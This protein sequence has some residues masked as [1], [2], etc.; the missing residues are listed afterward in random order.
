MKKLALLVLML[1]SVSAMAQ[2]VRV[3]G[4]ITSLDGDVLSVKSREGKDMKI[5]LAPD[6]Q[7][8]T[9]KKVKASEFKPGS[10]VGVTSVKNAEGHLVAKRVHA[11]GPQ[12]PQMHGAWDSIPGSM[13]TNSNITEI[14][15]MG[16]GSELTLKNKDGEQKILVDS[17][18]EYFNFVPGTRADLKPGATIFTG[19]RVEGDKLL[20]QRV[21][22]SKDGVKPPQ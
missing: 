4:T 21:A 15:K 20:T 10:Y 13:M 1:V 2:N 19:A 14:T 5:Q 7:V 6:A 11:L 17:K 22:V 9:T 8:V 16:K 18:T 12:V 3:R